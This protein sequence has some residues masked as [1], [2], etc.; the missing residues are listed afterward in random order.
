MELINHEVMKL[1]RDVSG[2]VPREIGFPNDAFAGK[3]SLQLSC[4]GVALGALA[5]VTHNVEHVTMPV[6]HTGNETQP[7]AVVVAIEQAGVA[8]LTV[9]KVADY[10]HRTCIGRPHAKCGT[11]GNEVRTHRGAGMDMIKGGRHTR[12]VL[13]R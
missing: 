5:A 13:L 11:T 3:W 10:I 7:M 4:V 6:A 9:V 2:L 1:R 12:W 8:A